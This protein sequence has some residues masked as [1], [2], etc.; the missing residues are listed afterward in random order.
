MLAM[1]TNGPSLP[2]GSP[3]PNVAVKPMTFGIYREM[4]STDTM[5]VGNSRRRN[6][7]F[8]GQSYGITTQFG[9]TRIKKEIYLP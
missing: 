6:S 3:D 4:K 2:S 9:Y 8:V 5:E 7:A 1:C